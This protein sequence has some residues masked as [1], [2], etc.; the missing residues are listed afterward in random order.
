MSTVLEFPE[1]ETHDNGFN[2]RLLTK[3]AS[4][5]V[6][7]TCSHYLD[8]NGDRVVLDDIMKQEIAAHIQAYAK[9]ALR[10]IAFAYKDLVE[11]E[12]GPEH[13]DKEDGSKLADIE[14]SGLTL[15]AIAGI[16]D[17]IRKEVPGAV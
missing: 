16:K 9:Q 10:T 13:D 5:I 11:G 1:G 8:A 3:G 17:I 15:I 6:V 14:L 7:E 2:K 4:E 12:G